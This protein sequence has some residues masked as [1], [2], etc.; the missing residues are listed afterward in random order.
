MSHRIKRTSKRR[1]IFK[2]LTEDGF[3]F[4]N[5]FNFIAIFYG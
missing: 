3:E 1:R 4:F 5:L 2:L